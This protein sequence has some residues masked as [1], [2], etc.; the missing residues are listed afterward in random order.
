MS[1][2]CVVGGI[3]SLLYKIRNHSEI[4]CKINTV[5]NKFFCFKSYL[6]CGNIPLLI[7]IISILLISN[8]SV[9]QRL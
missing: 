7:T 8:F 4:T 3:N 2:T 6:I 9:L 1:E 5:N